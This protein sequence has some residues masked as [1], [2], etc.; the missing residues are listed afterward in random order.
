MM[1]RSATAPLEPLAPQG[2]LGFSQVLIGDVVWRVFSTPGR[3]EHVVI[4]VAEQVRARDDVVMASL[5]SVIWPM[6]LALPLLALGVWAAVRHAVKPLRELGWRVAHRR[7]DGAEPLPLAGVP[8]EAR[9]LV[10]E[11]NRLFGRMAALI[12][13]ERRFTADA[14]HELRTPIA[15]T[16]MQ[17][18]VAQGA[19][20]DAERA[21]ALAAT[22]Q[23]C[24]R[25]THLVEQLLQLARL[26]SQTDGVAS[27][28]ALLPCV[29]AVLSELAGTAAAR[30]QQLEWAPPDGHAWWSPAPEAL[31]HILL[32]NLLDNALRYSPDG[33]C[34]CVQ[35]QRVADGRVMLTVEDSGPGMTP[36][37]MNRLGERFFRVVGS[38]QSG[39]GLGWS[40]VTRIAQMNGIAWQLARST[41][42]GGLR[43]DV[44]WAESSGTEKEQQ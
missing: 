29:S 18:Q 36:D 6:A 7:P 24:D 37:H 12:E 21:E 16:R 19:T 15:A 26:E 13:S 43:V 4:Q 32:R 2:L 42:L 33:A 27:P 14:A 30:N 8:R 38:G 35:V 10:H 22:V 5:R 25:A 9:P 31:T 23:G 40:I 34:V 39:S 3:D 17:A 20:S 11:L 41:R 1:V 28:S 44:T